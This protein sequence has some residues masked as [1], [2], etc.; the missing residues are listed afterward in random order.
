MLMMSPVLWI[1]WARSRF[2]SSVRL[3]IALEHAAVGALEDVE[4]RRLDVGVQ[5]AHAAQK[6]VRI[7]HLLLHVL[8]QSLVL[9]RG[10]EVIGDV[11]LRQELAIVG[12]DLPFPVHDEDAVGGRLERRRMQREGAAQLALGP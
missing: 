1:V 9:P 5:L 12:G 7:P 10:D 4:T 6:A 3:G 2:W 8:E 11:P